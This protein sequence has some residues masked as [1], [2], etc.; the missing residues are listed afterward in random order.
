MNT[1]LVAIVFVAALTV[2]GV[3]TGVAVLRSRQ[4][5]D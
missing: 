4:A 1:Q 5:A 2:T 3:G